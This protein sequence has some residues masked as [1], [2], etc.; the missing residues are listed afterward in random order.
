MSKLNRILYAMGVIGLIIAMFIVYKNAESAFEIRFLIGYVIYLF[1]LSFYFLGI[2]IF[3][4][5]GLKW[6]ELRKRLLKFLRLTFVNCVLLYGLIFAS[7]YFFK[8]SKL[9]LVKI[10]YT[11]VSLAFGVSFL[12]L[13]F[14]KR[15]LVK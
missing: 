13:V 12:D 8:T 11:S 10:L 6:V 5:R 3:R 9:N 1:L 15:G 4:L 2:T 14:L 7:D